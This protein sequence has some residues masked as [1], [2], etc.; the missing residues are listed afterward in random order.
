[1]SLI[2]KRIDNNLSRIDQLVDGIKNALKRL[3][4]KIIVIHMT[5]YFIVSQTAA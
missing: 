3:N 1:M 4:R 2:G 5:I